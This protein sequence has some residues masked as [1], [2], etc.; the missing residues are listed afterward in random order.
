VRIQAIRG[1]NLASLRGDFAIELD[2]PPLVHAGL[3]GIHGPIGAGKSTL[4]DAMCLA[5]YARTPRLSNRGGA[6]LQQGGDGLRSHDPRTLLRR[7]APA[8]HAE[9]DFV[10]CDGRRYQARW[11]VRRSRNTAFGRVQ[12]DEHTLTDMATHIRL[13][14]TT[15]ETRALLQ[16]KVGLSFE[17]FCRSVLLAQG[18]FLAFLQATAADRADLLERLTG[19][20]LYSALSRR[21]HERSKALAAQV[22]QAE[23]TARLGAPL[24]DEDRALL[25]ERISN[26][27]QQRDQAMVQEEHAAA[28]VAQ[29]QARLE[30]R[31]RYDAD[32]AE[33]TLLL[34]RLSAE[35]ALQHTA[36]Q[37][38]QS[39]LAADAW[40][41]P[42][43]QQLRELEVALAS[44][45]DEPVSVV[46]AEMATLQ[47]LQQQSSAAVAVLEQQVAAINQQL[48]S[49]Q[50]WLSHGLSWLELATATEQ[51]GVVADGS[52]ALA[53]AAQQR[54]HEA[55]QA[56]VAWRAGLPD[57]IDNIDDAAILMRL[58]ELYQQQED[59]AEFDASHA[60]T[61][62]NEAQRVL[63]SHQ[64]R[65]HLRAQR[66]QLVAGDPCPLCGSTT[67]PAAAQ[68]DDDLWSVATA[69]LHHV[70]QSL[71][72]AQQLAA[73][74]RGA[75]LALGVEPA[76]KRTT[77]KR[78]KTDA[79]SLAATIEQTHA[80]WQQS[81]T[82]RQQ[83]ASWLRADQLHQ[84]TEAELAFAIRDAE[85]A[86]Q[87]HAQGWHNL[88][89]HPLSVAV[90]VTTQW[91]PQQLTQWRQFA[92]QQVMMAQQ[93]PM[94]VANRDSMSS[95]VVDLRAQHQQRDMAMVRLQERH[96]IETAAA[97]H[98]QQQQSLWQQQHLLLLEHAPPGVTNAEAWSQSRHDDQQRWQH[99]SVSAEVNVRT[100]QHRVEQLVGLLRAPPPLVADDGLP[101]QQQLQQ[102]RAHRARTEQALA[103]AM[104]T[105]EEDNRRRQHSLGISAAQ[106]QLR[107]DAAIWSA[108][109]ELI[110]SADGSKFRLY[111]QGLTLE[112]LLTKANEQLAVF[113]PRYRLA[114]APSGSTTR[115]DLE[116]LV[117]DSDAGDE[118]R[119]TATLSGGESFLV[120]LSLALGLSSLSQG[121]AQLPVQSL[122][123]D[124]GFASLD[125]DAL[126]AALA[127]LEA[128]RTEARQIGVISHMPGIAERMGAVVRV[129]PMG[130]GSSK[131]QLG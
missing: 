116:L 60:T 75:R 130:N 37:S 115:F 70:K 125:A 85:H 86:H 98:R 26:A 66:Q 16:Q 103:A 18:G 54:A 19:T 121:H 9:V 57:D 67:H 51:A 23:L 108:L 20:S 89:A 123:I 49:L 100:W 109:A 79:A 92:Q 94:M 83:H 68:A 1:A 124:E 31:T 117:I 25:L 38:L 14:E 93:V 50:P 114:R 28:V 13:G 120:S 59:T 35:R 45:G 47:E 12:S 122:F 30:A 97:A 29:H 10:G 39:L 110:G 15:S 61:Q 126:E 127:A 74:A 129:V 52:T 71:T 48:L 107:H 58:A 36:Q 88:C 64:Q 41:L 131:V 69:H 111:A 34:Q 2:Q 33:H 105:L 101:A 42:R 53:T 84:R 65:H 80:E 91:Q 73:R 24:P 46:S 72:A 82:H 106:H 40:V 99:A 95:R 21:A 118:P 113:A 81:R 7:G 55:H 22:E 63:E 56:A 11:S 128:L 44:L 90:G 76:K 78:P 96:R 102:G 104:A 27:Q 112:V 119:S 6:P 5:L 87:A 77:K 3:F 62:V 17:E 4:L 8:G 43:L 32:L